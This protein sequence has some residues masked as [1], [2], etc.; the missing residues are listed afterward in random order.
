MAEVSFDEHVALSVVDD[1]S[2]VRSSST[3][4]RA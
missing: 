2:A 1:G 3:G 4:R